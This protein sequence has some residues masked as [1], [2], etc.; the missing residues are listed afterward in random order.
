[1]ITYIQLCEVLWKK[2]AGKKEQKRRPGGSGPGRAAGDTQQQLSDYLGHYGSGSF[3]SLPPGRFIA[4]FLE[5]PC[6]R[7]VGGEMVHARKDE[8]AN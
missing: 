5:D 8:V 7:E 6:E 1:M 2:N 4:E 3:F